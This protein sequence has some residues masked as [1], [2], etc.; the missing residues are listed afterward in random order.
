MLAFFSFLFY[1]SYITTLQP[2][3]EAEYIW[4]DWL[5]ESQ[6]DWIGFLQPL[7]SGCRP[8]PSG[9]LS[10]SQGQIES[11]EQHQGLP[12]GGPLEGHMGR[13][14][15]VPSVSHGVGLWPVNHI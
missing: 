4:Q 12:L 9:S 11:Q 15:R 5:E 10:I 14:W 8:P 2:R 13:I 3:A 7:R 1:H 6:D